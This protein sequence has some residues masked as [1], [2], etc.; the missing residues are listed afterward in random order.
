MPSELEP[1]LV[2]LANFHGDS[3]DMKGERAVV[4]HEKCD[5]HCLVELT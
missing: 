4:S 3:G 1:M 2:F 5:E